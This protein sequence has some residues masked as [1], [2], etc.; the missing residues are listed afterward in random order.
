VPRHQFRVY[1]TH[2]PLQLGW[3]DSGQLQDF[4]NYLG[5]M[6]VKL[7]ANAADFCLSFF[8]K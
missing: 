4:D 2:S 5:K 6:P 1:E 7:P 3:R 8:G